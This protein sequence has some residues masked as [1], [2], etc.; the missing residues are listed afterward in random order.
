MNFSKLKT[1]LFA[2][3]MMTLFLSNFSFGQKA[4]SKSKKKD[5]AWFMTLNAKSG[6]V[7]P[8]ESDSKKKC[9]RLEGVSKHTVIFSDRPD[10]F[11]K[12]V[13]TK[14]FLSKWGKEIFKDASPNAALVHKE[15]NPEN[16]G[17]ANVLDLKKLISHK[18]G[19]AVFEIKVL[20]KDYDLKNGTSLENISL[21][22]DDYT[23]CCWWNWGTCCN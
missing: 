11:Y 20:D 6:K 16:E 7:M 23:A 3:L 4:T 8:C 10:R 21:F 5:V 15:D 9:L 17:D 19:S 18:D 22:I 14:D 1:R 12:K 2:L 13:D